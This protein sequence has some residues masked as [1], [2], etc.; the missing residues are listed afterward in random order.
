MRNFAKAL[1]LVV[2]SA[3]LSGCVSSSTTNPKPKA[4]DKEAA[5]Q[6]YELGARYYR[7]GNY[8][9]AK[10]RLQRALELDPKLGIA[11]STLALT[12]VQL[13]VPRL[14]KENYEKAVRVEPRSYDVRNHYAVFLC[15]E[16]EFDEA[17]KQFDK[18]LDVYENDN[19]EVMLT[20][21]GVCMASK[22]DYELA[23]E[24]FRRALE[25]KI[26][27]GEALLQLCS[28]K[29]KTKDFLT[30]RAF[31]E[32]YLSENPSSPAVLYLLSQVEKE[33]G[34][35]RASTD[36]TNQLLREFPN[37]NESRYILDND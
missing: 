12:Y 27:Y 18:A 8:E 31:C 24:Y 36:Y 5:V 6:L 33:L 14:A 9:F 19:A 28:L 16:R 17:R 26:S 21:A 25:F 3:I 34:D 22:P 15:R 30:A 32:R 1:G 20:N 10:D 7:N 37:S 11:Y 29:Y 13:G 35:D 2:A 23:E 4:D